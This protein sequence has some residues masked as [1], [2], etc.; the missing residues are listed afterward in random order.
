MYIV[1]CTQQVQDFVYRVVESGGVRSQQIAIGGYIQV[2]GDLNQPQ[3][4][5]I[6]RQHARYGM[7]AE[8]DVDRTKE[9]I[10]LYYTLDKLP[11]LTKIYDAITHNVEVLNER[12]RRN[13][14]EAAIVTSAAIEQ[15]IPA[16][17]LKELEMSVV[18][19]KRDGREVTEDPSIAE[20]FRITRDHKGPPVP[21]TRAEQRRRNA[22][23][24][25]A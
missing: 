17:S 5:G 9:F 11:K 2:S 6:I 3:I 18:E 10:G 1:N 24:S 15:S 25:A 16:G 12:G 22:R 19:E 23:R 8:A 21:E 14:E 20:G 13:R 4:D 7:V